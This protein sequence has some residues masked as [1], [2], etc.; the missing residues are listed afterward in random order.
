[1]IIGRLVDGEKASWLVTKADFKGEKAMKDLTNQQTSHL[2]DTLG[3]WDRRI[4]DDLRSELLK[5]SGL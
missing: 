4:R 1:M 3:A 5:S 2:A